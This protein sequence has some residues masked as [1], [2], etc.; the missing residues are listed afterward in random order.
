MQSASVITV[1]MAIFCFPSASPIEQAKGGDTNY[2][3]FIAKTTISQCFISHGLLYRHV[4]LQHMS[5][6]LWNFEHAILNDSIPIRDNRFFRIRNTF[7]RDANIKVGISEQFSLLLWLVMIIVGVI[8]YFDFWRF[9]VRC[10]V[11][12]ERIFRLEYREDGRL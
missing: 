2:R 10:R 4:S 5:L 1:N 8:G 11:F 12:M 9:T 3:K 7:L 6:F